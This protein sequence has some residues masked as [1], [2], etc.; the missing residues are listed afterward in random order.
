MKHRVVTTLVSLMSFIL[1]QQVFCGQYPE[2]S[3]LSIFAFYVLVLVSLIFQVKLPL[4]AI[5]LSLCLCL[6]SADTSDISAPGNWTCKC[7]SPYQ[8]NQ[9]LTLGADCSTSCSCTQGITSV[10]KY[11][12]HPEFLKHHYLLL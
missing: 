2:Q 5:R 3:I 12:R 11:F 7:F 10:L 9:T 8:E 4:D 6:L 1:M